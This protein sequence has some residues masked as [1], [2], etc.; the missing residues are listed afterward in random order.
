MT[1]VAD[2][3]AEI[4]AN[5]LGISRGTAKICLGLAGIS[6]ARHG[7]TKRVAEAVL[8]SGLLEEIAEVPVDVDELQDAMDDVDEE[9]DE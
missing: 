9:V 1:G 7:E 8:L 5:E 3:A 2:T 6:T 4:L